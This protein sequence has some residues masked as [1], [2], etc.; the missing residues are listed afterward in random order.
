MRRIHLRNMTP[1]RWMRAKL[2]GNSCRPPA[3]MMCGRCASS[4]SSS[5][6]AKIRVPLAV[7][8]F[9]QFSPALNP[10]FSYLGEDVI[11]TDVLP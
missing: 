9:S 7:D 1:K 4:M 8:T 11:R 10:R 2:R 5:R 6:G 3:S